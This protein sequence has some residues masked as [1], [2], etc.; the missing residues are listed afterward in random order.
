MIMR[1]C[2]LQGIV[3]SGVTEEINELFVSENKLNLALSDANVLP[4]VSIT[5]VMQHLAIH[6]VFSV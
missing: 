4:T 6:H 5:K 2:C 3:P 1:V